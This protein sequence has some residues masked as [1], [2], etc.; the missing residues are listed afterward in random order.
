TGQVDGT[1]HN[2]RASDRLRLG[3]GPVP[4]RHRVARCDESGRHGRTHPACADPADR[5]G[6]RVRCRHLTPSLAVAG[7]RER[8]SQ[9][10]AVTI[11][12]TRQTVNRMWPTPT[13]G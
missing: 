10:I 7:P 5:L 13:P 9:T 12:L 3:P 6:C 4:D 2:G 11:G 1:V 8:V